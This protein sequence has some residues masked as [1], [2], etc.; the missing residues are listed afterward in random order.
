MEA[1]QTEP[2]TWPSQNYAASFF[3]TLPRDSRFLNCNFQKIVPSSNIDGETITFTCQRFEA[4]NCYN[5]SECCVEATVAIVKSDGISLPEKTAVVGTCNNILHSIFKNLRIKLNDFEITKQSSLYPYKSYI[6][7]CLTYS[8]YVK[9]C[10]LQSQGYY[11]DLSNHFSADNTN[12]G[13]LQR[14]CL[15]R[16]NFQPGNEF[17]A[18]GTTLIGRLHH[19]LITTAVPLPPGTKI[20]IEF[21]RSEDEFVILKPKTDP[22]KYKLKILHICLYMPIAQ[23]SQSVYQE[24][25]ALLTKPRDLQSGAVNIHYRRSELRTISIP[26]NAQEFNSDVLFADEGPVRVVLVLVDTKAKNGQFDLN[27]FEFRRDWE[28]KLK[29]KSNL[30]VSQ[31]NLTD[32]E[33]WEKRINDIEKESERRI[34]QIQE[35]FELLQSQLLPQDKGKGPKRGKKSN[36]ATAPP[37]ATT[38]ASPSQS[39]PERIERF[40]ISSDA[41]SSSSFERL[42]SRGSL[43]SARG[44]HDTRP[45]QDRTTIIC[46]DPDPPQPTPPDEPMGKVYVRKI[47]LLLNGTPVDQVILIYF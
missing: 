41:G 8:S 31:E 40:N 5:F 25:S 28:Y 45:L 30:N 18:G 17:K 32:K 4:P 20:S 21:D 9:S 47:E 6:S 14:S 36:P 22:E 33:L 26:S 29:K 44:L 38:A 46:D 10:Q 1:Q 43:T 23:L 12:S 37:A 7:T 24:F 34:R 35:K 11:N 19:D 27:P 16:K 13:F 39:L 2:L 42:S 3:A 15:F